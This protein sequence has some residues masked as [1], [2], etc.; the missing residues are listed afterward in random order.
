M[1]TK[2]NVGLVMLFLLGLAILLYP[3]LSNKWNERRSQDLITKYAEQAES[4]SDE[5]YKK[6]LVKAKKYNES[7]SGSEVPDAFSVR[8]GI[9]DENYEAVLNLSGDGILAYIRIP[10]IKVNI[11][12]YHYTYEEILQKGAG[13]LLGSSLPI[14]GRDT[15][16]VITAHRGLPRAKLFTDLNLIKKGDFFTIHVLKE[17]LVYQVRYIEVVEPTET[18]SLAIQK[19][20]DQVTLITCTPYS[21]NSHRL[22][23]HGER[24]AKTPKGYPK[25]DTLR[26]RMHWLPAFILC[27]AVGIMLG[28]VSLKIIA[29][30]R[31]MWTDSNED[32]DS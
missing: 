20:K 5:D 10:K 28:V 32:E 30:I 22:M 7:L 21:V 26:E 24:V 17:E 3:Y 9:K 1:K 11:P 4:L 18:E 6:E 2:Q 23:V 13:H 31:N 16:S 19:D 12:I 25:A 14:G 29:I 8:D 27:T 15:H